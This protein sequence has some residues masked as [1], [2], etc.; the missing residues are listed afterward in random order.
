RRWCGVRK[1]VCRAATHGRTAAEARSEGNTLS[2]PVPESDPEGGIAARGGCAMRRRL[3]IVV[4][5]TGFIVAAAFNVPS[6]AQ[7]RPSSIA[8]NT[9]PPTAVLQKY[10][11]PCH[12]QRMKTV[13]LM[14]DALDL[15]HMSSNIEV[16]EKVARKVRTGAMP[17]VGRPRPD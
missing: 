17:P 5:A 1:F 6:S 11:V 16:W 8:P 2:R 4:A 9:P 12:N 10:C 13:G 14:L 15:A 7:D 3:A